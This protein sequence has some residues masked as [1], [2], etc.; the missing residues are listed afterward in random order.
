M[1]NRKKSNKFPYSNEIK[2]AKDAFKRMIDDMSDEEFTIFSFTIMDAI[3]SLEYELNT[4]EI[5]F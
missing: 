3:E 4:E 2:S 5:P 1:N